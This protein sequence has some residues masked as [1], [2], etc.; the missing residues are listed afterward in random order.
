M[1]IAK[2]QL[3]YV[4]VG[5]E[6]VDAGNVRVKQVSAAHVGCIP[7]LLDQH[8]LGLGAQLDSAIVG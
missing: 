6:I 1:R 4:V 3:A 5:S 2:Q 7:T 8:V